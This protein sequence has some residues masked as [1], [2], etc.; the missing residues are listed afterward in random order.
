MFHP[1]V[2]H[3]LIIMG[4]GC[5]TSESFALAV[6]QFLTRNSSLFSHLHTHR[7]RLS[8]YDY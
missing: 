8:L 4:D 3:P 5:V 7:T 1:I 2:L 6:G